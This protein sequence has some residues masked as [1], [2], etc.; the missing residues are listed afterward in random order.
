MNGISSLDE[1]RC[2]S[3][4][5]LLTKERHDNNKDEE[6]H[7]VID[8]IYC[9]RQT[10]RMNKIQQKRKKAAGVRG[11]PNSL[12]DKSD[13]ELSTTRHTL[14]VQHKKAQSPDLFSDLH[15]IGT[16]EVQSDHIPNV[17]PSLQWL[18]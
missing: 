6:Y 13:G 2:E 9:A 7:A 10:R 1:C 11:F 12:V 5:R 3:G 15:Q 18:D 17:L 14:P 8:D 4:Q 16:K